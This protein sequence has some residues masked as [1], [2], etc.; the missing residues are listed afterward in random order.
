MGVGLAR[1][2]QQEELGGLMEVLHT[3]MVVVV[4]PLDVR[5]SPQNCM[6]QQVDSTECQLYLKYNRK[7]SL[8]WS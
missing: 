4:T 7:K 1:K 6:L 3:W 2:K 5:Q 8:G